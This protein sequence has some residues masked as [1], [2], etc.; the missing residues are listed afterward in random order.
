MMLNVS[1]GRDVGEQFTENRRESLTLE[2]GGFKRLHFHWAFS[3]EGTLLSD[4]GVF[5][6][7]ACEVRPLK[8][9]NIG[10]HANAWKQHNLTLTGKFQIYREA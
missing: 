9:Q 4:D 8:R 2:S 1:K 6:R 3:E 5:F 10:K 7:S